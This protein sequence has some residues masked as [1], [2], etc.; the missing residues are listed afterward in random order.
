MTNLLAVR[1]LCNAIANTF[2]PDDETIKLALFNEGID[3]EAGATPKDPQIFRVAKGL[4]I[5][6]VEGSRSEGGVSTSV[7]SE[8]A[9]KQSLAIWCGYYGLKA[10]D[11]LGDY[12]RVIESGANLW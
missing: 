12:M 9:I 5:G 6:Y 7:M 10:E 1:S 8:E 4:V 11:E 2:Y 3:A